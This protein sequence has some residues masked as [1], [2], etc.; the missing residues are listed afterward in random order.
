M[1]AQSFSSSSSPWIKVLDVV[2]V[3][4]CVENPSEWVRFVPC[5]MERTRSRWSEHFGPGQ[6]GK[7]AKR[8][9]PE[10]RPTSSIGARR[11]CAM[12]SDRVRV[13][14]IVVIDGVPLELAPKVLIDACHQPPSARC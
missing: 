11:T 4:D 9:A 12:S 13:V 7:D 8:A 6:V 5:K 14:G 1:G 2:L 3:L 10:I